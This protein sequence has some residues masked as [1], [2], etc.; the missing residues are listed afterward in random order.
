[1]DEGKITLMVARYVVHH[2]EDLRGFFKGEH[3]FNL[4]GRTIERGHRADRE[5]FRGYAVD[6]LAEAM[7]RGKF[8]GRGVPKSPNRSC[9]IK[10]AR[11]VPVRSTQEGLTIVS[12]RFRETKDGL[13]VMLPL[14][15]SR[16][17][18][19]VLKDPD[20]FKGYSETDLS[21]IP[22]GEGGIFFK[23][24]VDRLFARKKW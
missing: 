6:I 24:M 10:N 8:F 23:K 13:L 19:N 18:T 1:M 4:E 7:L 5:T 3:Y 16:M 12:K 9:D 11:L 15:T 20:K 22:G 14:I 2:A 21:S 17:Y